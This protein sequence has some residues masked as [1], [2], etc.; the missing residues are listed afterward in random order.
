MQMFSMV[1]FS[2]QHTDNTPLNYLAWR[3]ASVAV[4][5]FVVET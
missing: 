4:L 2:G 1:H 3:G 5:I